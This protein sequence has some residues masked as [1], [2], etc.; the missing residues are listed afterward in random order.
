MARRTAITKGWTRY[1]LR[2]NDDIGAAV[3]GTNAAGQRV[4]DIAGARGFAAYVPRQQFFR[5]FGY[6]AVEPFDGQQ[7]YACDSPYGGDEHS[8]QYFG[9]DPISIGCQLP[10]G[11]SG[12]GWIINDSE[13]NSVTS[14]GIDDPFDTY[15]PY[16]A[17]GAVGLYNKVRNR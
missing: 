10:P 4:A 9:P 1:G 2:S 5:A 15:G 14:F 17:K 7:L 13:L 16:F 3:L 6:P 8:P 11:S 12:G